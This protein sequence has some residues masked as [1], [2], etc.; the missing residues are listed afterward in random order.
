MHKKVVEIKRVSG[1]DLVALIHDPSEK[2]D[3]FFIKHVRAS[4]TLGHSVRN[5]V[6]VLLENG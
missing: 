1:K 6:V 2:R 3:R 5:W 4:P